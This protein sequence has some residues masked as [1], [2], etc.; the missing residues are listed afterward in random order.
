MTFC[1]RRF[2]VMSLGNGPFSSRSVTRTICTFRKRGVGPTQLHHVWLT[3]L[4]DFFQPQVPGPL[5]HRLIHPVRRKKARKRTRQSA[6]GDAYD[7]GGYRED[8]WDTEN[9]GPSMPFVPL[10]ALLFL[11]GDFFEGFWQQDDP[12]SVPVLTPQAGGGIEPLPLWVVQQRLSSSRACAAVRWC[13]EWAI[14][15][16]L[17]AGPVPDADECSVSETVRIANVPHDR[18]V[19][20]TSFR[21]GGAVEQGSV[22]VYQPSRSAAVWGP[23]YTTAL[24]A[25]KSVC[26]CDVAWRPHAVYRL[27]AVLSP[28]LTAS[29]AAS[30]GKVVQSPHSDVAWLEPHWYCRVLAA[31]KITSC[32][33]SPQGDGVTNVAIASHGIPTWTNAIR[34]TVPEAEV[35]GAAAYLLHNPPSACMVQVVHACIIEAHL[36]R[37]QKPYTVAIRGRP[38]IWS[39]STR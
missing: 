12:A 23:E 31:S 13:R 39:I 11:I 8:G 14:V 17:P 16:L 18:N 4:H 19:A 25:I 26:G 24:D 30:L 10:A 35:I 33:A 38:H 15:L 29:S 1:M 2:H 34:G 37:R 6:T 20:V 21:D 9:P 3:R 22:V 5:T 36:R 32:D 27:K 7:V 28:E